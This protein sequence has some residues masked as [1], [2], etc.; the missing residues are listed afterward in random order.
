M[1][2]EAAAV[3][4]SASILVM[5]TFVVI[6]VGVIVVNNLFHKYWKPVTLFSSIHSNINN[7]RFATAEE[8]DQMAPKMDPK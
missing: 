8:L 6:S 5:M 3:F 4:M 1:D 2:M 7:T